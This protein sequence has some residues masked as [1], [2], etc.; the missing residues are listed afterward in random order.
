MRAAVTAAVAKFG[1]DAFFLGCVL[2]DDG[3]PVD[4]GLDLPDR[5]LRDFRAGYSSRLSTGPDGFIHPESAA[6]A[7]GALVAAMTQALWDDVT[8]GRAHPAFASA[9]A[10]AIGNMARRWNVAA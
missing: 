5:D 8:S 2:A 1:A 10:E 6:A 3:K 4:V 9:R 7:R